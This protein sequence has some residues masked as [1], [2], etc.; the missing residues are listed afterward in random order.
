MFGWYILQYVHTYVWYVHLNTYVQYIMYVYAYVHRCICVC[1]MHR[2]LENTDMRCG[3]LL[4]W[5]WVV[6]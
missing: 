4:S 3:P 2:L 6:V 1:A 5:Y